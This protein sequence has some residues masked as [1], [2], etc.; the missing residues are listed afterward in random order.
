MNK[1]MSNVFLVLG[2]IIML[3]SFGMLYLGLVAFLVILIMGG[4]VVCLGL[5]MKK[6]DKIE[7]KLGKFTL[8]PKD[9]QKVLVTCEKCGRIYEA[10]YG[11][12]PYCQ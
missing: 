8:L 5:S 3:A 4:A 7:D 11:R 1:L 12:C 10:E 9:E 2:A 6:L